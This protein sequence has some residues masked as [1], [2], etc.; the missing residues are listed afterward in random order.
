MKGVRTSAFCPLPRVI[1]GEYQQRDRPER[2]VTDRETVISPELRHVMS[3]LLRNRASVASL[4]PVV[5]P[6]LQMLLIRAEKVIP[7]K[8]LL[9]R[10][11]VLVDS[12]AGALSKL[13]GILYHRTFL[14]KEDKVTSNC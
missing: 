10:Q 8:K 2:C 14:H 11:D 6:S 3:D 12:N 9:L 13:D 1:L 7:G 5:V 4:S